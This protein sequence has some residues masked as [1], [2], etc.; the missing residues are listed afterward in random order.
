[1]CLVLSWSRCS[2]FT[3]PVASVFI[4]WA[5]N[6]FLLGCTVVVHSFVCER[7]FNRFALR[8]TIVLVC[9]GDFAITLRH[10]PSS[11]IFLTVGENFF[12]F[13][14][15]FQKVGLKKKSKKKNTFFLH[16][17]FNFFFL[18]SLKQPNCTFFGGIK[19]QHAW[20]L[21]FFSWGKTYTEFCIFFILRCHNHTE[22]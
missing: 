14:T 1:M 9:E 12:L 11:Q 19:K 6:L 5:H 21:F 15:M 3:T 13:K 17:G 7:F 2:F 16:H 20:K 10:C 18:P 8:Q 22:E 4:I